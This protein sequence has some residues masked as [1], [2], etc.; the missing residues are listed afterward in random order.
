MRK[1]IVILI[2]EDDDGH[3]AL[4]QRNLKRSGIA[5]KMI[6]FNNGEEVL[7]F[8]IKEEG[9][10]GPVLS[11]PYLLLLDIRMPKVDGIEVLKRLKSHPEL[12]KMPVIMVTTT[13]DPREVNRCHDGMQ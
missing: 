5:N 9:D 3:A 10:E 6:R 12:K 8:L 11:T 4:V 2:A 13:D 7:K 1:D